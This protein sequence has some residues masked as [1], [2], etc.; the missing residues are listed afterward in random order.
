MRWLVHIKA[1][2]LTQLNS[3]VWTKTQRPIADDASLCFPAN[4]RVII[5]VFFARFS[6]YVCYCIAAENGSANKKEE[7]KKEEGERK[8]ETRSDD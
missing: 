6:R 8:N 7:K 1:Q 3:Y 2:R 4:G 5:K